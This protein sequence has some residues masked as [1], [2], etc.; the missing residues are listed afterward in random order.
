VKTIKING[1]SL[2]DYF[3]ENRATTRLTR[4]N[5][6]RRSRKK[7]GKGQ[8]FSSPISSDDQS[9]RLERT[10]SL[11]EKPSSRVKSPRSSV[12]ITD[13]RSSIDSRSS[14]GP[15][16]TARRSMRSTMC[17]VGRVRDFN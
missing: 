11:R 6:L 1:L 3:L 9:Q 17:I 15:T 16:A 5:S 13:S 12:S 14:Y 10:R 4:L 8:R 7:S 2:E